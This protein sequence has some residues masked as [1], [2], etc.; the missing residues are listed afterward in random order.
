M[1]RPNE[2]QRPHDIIIKA[3]SLSLPFAPILPGAYGDMLDGFALFQQD[4][5]SGGAVSVIFRI[6]AGRSH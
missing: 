5:S 6:F 3:S 2:S 4:L 1:A